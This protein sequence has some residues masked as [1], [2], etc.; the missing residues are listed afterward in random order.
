MRSRTAALV[1]TII[2]VLWLAGAARAN[3]PTGGY[4]STSSTDVDGC[5]IN[6]VDG[7]HATYRDIPSGG[8]C[9][10]DWSP[11]SSVRRIYLDAARLSGTGTIQIRLYT[12]GGGTQ[13]V[14]RQVTDAEL[15]TVINL[16]TT[17][18][19]V[20]RVMVDTSGSA[21][22][23]YEVQAYDADSTPPATPTG[24]TLSTGGMHNQ[25]TATWTANNDT[26]LAGYRLNYRLQPGGSWVSVAGITG[27]SRTVTGLTAGTYEATVEAYDTS[28]NYSPASSPATVTVTEPP[29]IPDAP[30]GLTAT[31][32]D[33]QV[34]LSWSVSTHASGY[35]VYRDG[36]LVNGSPLAGTTY[37]DT[38]VTNGTTYAYHVTAVNE[39]GESA[40]ST[41]V[42]AT[43][44]KP[45]PGPNAFT[46]S[47]SGMAQ[48]VTDTLG[49]LAQPWVIPAG[50]T[51][52]SSIL[53]LGIQLLRR[54]NGR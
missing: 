35:N 31:A 33:G 41:T 30:G 44:A 6:P 53:G 1:V 40:A 2:C 47:L 8:V 50:L 16:G 15:G 20:A 26:D 42:T 4:L 45:P 13:L 29:P 27:T 32:G 19:N 22:R 7:D 17:Y 38:G 54:W 18:T 37:T 49:S 24:L 21:Y 25:F 36:V 39:S 14:T 43:P 11:S 52:A 23:V 12:S 48:S 10:W 34:E 51:V 3:H 46:I 9:R 28:G 5:G